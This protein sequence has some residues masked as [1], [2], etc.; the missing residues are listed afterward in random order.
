M[1]WQVLR[2]CT[3]CEKVLSY[4][5]LYLQTHGVCPHCGNDSRDTIPSNKKVVFNV[6][7]VTPWWNFWKPV[8]I[9]RGKDNYSKKWLSKNYEQRKN[10]K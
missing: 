8:K 9:Y 3:V 6:K 2:V 7:R 4:S 5:Q 1:S 10:K